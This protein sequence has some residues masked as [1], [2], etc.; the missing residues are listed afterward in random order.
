MVTSS[1]VGTAQVLSSCV[2]AEYTYVRKGYCLYS[3]TPPGNY[4]SPNIAVGGVYQKGNESR[5]YVNL[6]NL[7][8]LMGQ[9]SLEDIPTDDECINN[10]I[11]SLIPGIFPTISGKW[12]DT[13]EFYNLVDIQA[14][15]SENQNEYFCKILGFGTGS[16]GKYKISN[17][18]RSGVEMLA[19]TT[20]INVINAQAVYN[21][22]EYLFS[23]ATFRQTNY[24]SVLDGFVYPYTEVG[25]GFFMSGFNWKNYFN[26]EVINGTNTFPFFGW[27]GSRI[28]SINPRNTL[29]QQNSTYNFPSELLVLAKNYNPLGIVYAGQ[30]I[31]INSFLP[32]DNTQTFDLGNRTYQETINPINTIRYTGICPYQQGRGSYDYYNVDL[33]YNT[34]NGKS[35]YVEITSTIGPEGAQPGR[36]NHFAGVCLTDY[37]SNNLNLENVTN[38]SNTPEDIRNTYWGTNK[39]SYVAHNSPMCYIETN[40]DNNL[41]NPLPW[42]TSFSY[43]GTTSSS[44]SNSKSDN[45]PIL[46]EGITTMVI[47]GAYPLYRGAWENRWNG[48]LLYGFTLISSLRGI[49]TNPLDQYYTSSQFWDAQYTD[50]SNQ[51]ITDINANIPVPPNPP[52]RIKGG[53]IVLYEGQKVKAGSYV[54]STINM[55]GNIGIPHFF[56]PS[57]KEISLIEGES[58]QLLGDVYSKYQFNQGGLIV[59]ISIDDR[60]P[61]IPPSCAVPVG[62]VL[63]DIVGYGNPTYYDDNISQNTKYGPRSGINVSYSFLATYTQLEVNQ[64]EV[65]HVGSREIL[66]KLFPMKTVTELSGITVCS[67]NTEFVNDIKPYVAAFGN[68][69]YPTFK[70]GGY[71]YTYTPIV[72]KIKS[73][74]MVNSGYEPFV[75]YSQD[76][77][78]YGDNSLKLKQ[79]LN[80]ALYLN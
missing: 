60:I 41:Q 34:T 66:I 24:S 52:Y 32:N 44:S 69:Q 27:G 50:P 16:I 29:Y 8:T 26:L 47:S 74:Y 13:Q 65:N 67:S 18:A 73:N 31:Q 22:L 36:N 43:I 2:I 53:K 61:P 59:I 12:S 19:Y 46:K 72:Q 28:G 15:V 57:A 37:W 70:N 80:D 30:G 10:Y 42:N 35:Q 40:P 9:L 58:T 63:E 62:V 11:T 79:N 20:K 1:R 64:Y 3:Y 6:S 25:E 48:Q 17:V 45:S 7:G 77:N 33:D 75:I 14:Q 4:P 54:Y 49:G 21:S 68:F 39:Q 76:I 78:V 5:S 71:S 56:P 55:C 51:E 38:S 23:I